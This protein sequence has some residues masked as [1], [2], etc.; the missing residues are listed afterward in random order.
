MTKIA[1]IAVGIVHDLPVDLRAALEAN[2]K[3]LTTWTD[4]TAIARNEWICWIETA[5]KSETR[6]KRITWGTENLQDGKRRPCCWP[7][8][9][10][11][12]CTKASAVI[13]P[14]TRSRGPEA[15]PVRAVRRNLA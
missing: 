13:A 14:P 4:L 1:E 3:A 9:S 10:H 8:C 11:R 12:D 2:P 5:R 7:G 6:G 15:A